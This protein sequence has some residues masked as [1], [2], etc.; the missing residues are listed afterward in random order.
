MELQR[1]S[2]VPSLFGVD[3][4]CFFW[5]VA[6][7][8]NS[9]D[10]LT[11]QALAAAAQLMQ[12][13]GS[14]QSVAIF[15]TQFITTLSA[16]AYILSESLANLEIRIFSL[17]HPSFQLHS[18]LITDHLI[19]F[20]ERHGFPCRLLYLDDFPTIA[21]HS[22]LLII[23]RI[24][25]RRCIAFVDQVKPSVVVETGESI[26]VEPRLYSLRARILRRQLIQRFRKAPF[27]DDLIFAHTVTLSGCNSRML[28]TL[29]SICSELKGPISLHQDSTLALV[30]PP[31]KGGVVLLLLPYL[32]HRKT[33]WPFHKYTRRILRKLGLF[34][35][36]DP[37]RDHP[38]IHN[39]ANSISNDRDFGGRQA[40]ATIYIKPH[41]KNNHETE[42][43]R[44][45]LL[46][47]LD[48]ADR[49]TVHSVPADLPLEQLVAGLSATKALSSLRILGFGTNLLAAKVFLYPS[50]VPVSLVDSASSLITRNVTR[51]FDFFIHRSEFL[52]RRHVSR[53]LASLNSG[54]EG[55]PSP[56]ASSVS[57]R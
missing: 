22:N 56:S 37:Y 23:P 45:S 31:E 43:I 34:K 40:S 19:P 46:R 53:L 42:V 52:R 29:V 28:E 54:L 7:L 24:D 26:G 55:L 39:A 5:P 20:C 12:S 47:C 41:P 1:T 11:S 33:K 21:L 30:G 9:N 50:A 36:P 13:R 6:R 57:P 16:F 51:V 3:H 35:P 8:F 14:V 15:S 44:T 25:H 48:S 49:Y 2:V 32:T 10:K 17:R 4:L 27:L 18:E 38:V